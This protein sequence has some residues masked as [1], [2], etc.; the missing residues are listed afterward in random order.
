MESIGIYTDIQESGNRDKYYHKLFY[1]TCSVCGA[2]VEMRLV[3]FK[4][5]CKKCEHYTNTNERN[6]AENQIHN[7]RLNQILN[8]MIDRCYNEKDR[9]YRWYGAKGIKICNDWKNNRKNFEIWALNSG[10]EDNLTIDRIDENKDYCPENCRW[11]S[12]SNNSKYKSSTSYINVD[13]VI[14]TGQDWAREL[15]FG[16][17]MINTYI[18]KYGLDNTIE[19]I[20]R[21]Q[22]ISTLIPEHKQSY[23]D[24]YMN[25]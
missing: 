12:L 11:V 3:D 20:K 25:Q 13:G 8:G 4:I 2:I 10:Y 14:H 15:G 16:Q 24:L 23:Y 1:G 5:R 9:A 21:Y 17:N 6:I 22:K 7:K 18:R 19:F